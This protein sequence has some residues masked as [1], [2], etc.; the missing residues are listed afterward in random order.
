M[1]IISRLYHRRERG[2][3]R[4]DRAKGKEGEGKRKSRER[5]RERVC[6]CICRGSKPNFY[7][8]LIFLFNLILL[9][10]VLKLVK[11]KNSK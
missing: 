3:E 2:K 1:S 4:F 8:K 9:T 10:E 6:V 5:E 7:F 11:L